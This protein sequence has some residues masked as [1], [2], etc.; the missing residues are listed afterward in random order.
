MIEKEIWFFAP[1]AGV[2][3]DC[4]DS[5][6]N[7]R[8]QDC[9]QAVTP[10]TSKNSLIWSKSWE[11]VLNFRPTNTQSV[12]SGKIEAASESWSADSDKTTFGATSK[13]IFFEWFEL[14]DTQ[15]IWCMSFWNNN[16]DGPISILFSYYVCEKVK[17]RKNLIHVIR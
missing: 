4:I 11:E 14:V 6:V 7:F 12:S 3:G 17:D 8:A 9:N 13:P 2:K 1:Q 5:L 15:R 10:K 16:F